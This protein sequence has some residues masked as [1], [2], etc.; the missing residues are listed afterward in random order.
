MLVI[1]RKQESFFMYS[2]DVACFNWHES[3]S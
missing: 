2:F 3:W 1:T